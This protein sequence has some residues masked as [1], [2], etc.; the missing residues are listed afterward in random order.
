MARGAGGVPCSAAAL[1][2]GRPLTKGSNAKVVLPLPMLHVLHDRLCRVGIL[3]AA[4]RITEAQ[5]PGRVP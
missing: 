2:L 1:L 5:E 3:G 4:Q